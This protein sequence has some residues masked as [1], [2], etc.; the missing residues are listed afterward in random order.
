MLAKQNKELPSKRRSLLRATADD[1]PEREGTRARDT[2]GIEG[3]I[4]TRRRGYY[5][6]CSLETDTESSGHK[7]AFNETGGVVVYELRFSIEDFRIYDT[8][9]SERD[10]FGSL[11]KW[12]LETSSFSR[13]ESNDTTR[14]RG[15]SAKDIKR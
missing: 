12:A 14:S 3:T 8:S 7:A 1:S 10:I 11:L 13:E 15:V 2:K 4:P 9:R 6:G 5:A